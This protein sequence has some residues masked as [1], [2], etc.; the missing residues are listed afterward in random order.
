M[1]ISPTPVKKYVYHNLLQFLPINDK[2]FKKEFAATVIES[3]AIP[4][5]SIKTDVV[6]ACH[7]DHSCDESLRRPQSATKKRKV[8]TPMTLKKYELVVQPE[9]RHISFFRGIMPSLEAFD[10]DDVIQFQMGVLQLVA[11]IKS[12]RRMQQISEPNHQA[13][14][15]TII[16]DADDDSPTVKMEYLG[17]N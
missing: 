5:E 16:N 8:A 2:K 3:N 4:V 12:H 13:S 11:D 1:A 9:D 15:S 6:E 7:S 14:S 10:D 17:F